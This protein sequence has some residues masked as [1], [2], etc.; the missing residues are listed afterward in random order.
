MHSCKPVLSQ[1]THAPIKTDLE[2]NKELGCPRRKG[3]SVCQ[4][5]LLYISEANGTMVP[6]LQQGPPF[7]GSSSST[8]SGRVLQSDIEETNY[9]ILSEV[10]P[11]QTINLFRP[12]NVSAYLFIHIH[13][14]KSTCS[15]FCTEQQ[16]QHF[17]QALLCLVTGIGIELWCM[18][19]I[20][21]GICEELW[22]FDCLHPNS[23]NA[24]TSAAIFAMVFGPRSSSRKFDC[25][26][27]VA[28]ARNGWPRTCNNVKSTNMADLRRHLTA[29]A[30]R[31]YTRQLAFLELCPTC[32]NDFIDKDVFESQ[33]G[34]RGELCNNRQPQRRGA[35]AQVQWELLYQQVEATMAS[36]H[37]QMRTSLFPNMYGDKFNIVIPGQYDDTI[38]PGPNTSLASPSTSHDA[39]DAFT[40][41][42]AFCS[43]DDATPYPTLDQPI[44]E[45]DSDEEVGQEPPH[46]SFCCIHSNSHLIDIVSRLRRPCSVW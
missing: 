35:N 43:Q 21:P 3:P 9:D 27:F 6:P 40:P 8:D 29:R 2:R 11:P 37:A 25:P 22:W 45:S 23:F 13:C 1:A 14:H 31:G 28:E 15:L 32:N 36:Q 24:A 16:L 18:E 41:Q 26:V 7:H 42:S 44:F 19:I 46:V 17:N 30:G 10:Q 33:H 12:S 20:W 34:Y 5:V 4:R 38:L 39:V